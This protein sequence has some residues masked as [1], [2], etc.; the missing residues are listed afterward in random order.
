MTITETPIQMI[1][2]MT[3][4]QQKLEEQGLLNDEPHLPCIT[5]HLSDLKALKAKLEETIKK[6]DK[7]PVTICWTDEKDKCSYK[8]KPKNDKGGNMC[9]D[10][11]DKVPVLKLLGGGA[12]K[13]KRCKK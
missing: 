9:I 2:R 10:Q 3:E 8:Y 6:I 7:L 13:G 12:D 1:D 5:E 11:I 4:K